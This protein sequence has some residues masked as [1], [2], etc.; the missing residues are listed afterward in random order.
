MAGLVAK[1]PSLRTLWVY[2]YGRF[3]HADSE[4]SDKADS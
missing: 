2:E 3:L 4:G 1:Q